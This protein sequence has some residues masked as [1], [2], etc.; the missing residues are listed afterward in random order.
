MAKGWIKIDRGIMEN[1]IYPKKRAFT[2]YEAWLH[3]LL[4]ANYS[5]SKILDNGQLIEVKR[6]QVLTSQL[7]LSTEFGWSRN[8]VRR[9][10]EMLEND[11]MLV[12]KTTRKYTILTICNYE[13][14]QGSGTTDDTTD[15]TTEGQLTEHIKECKESKEE[16]E[17]REYPHLDK[18]FPLEHCD[19]VAKKDE[20][21]VINSGYRDKWPTMFQKYLKGIGETE[22]HIGDYKKHFFN[23]KRKH[24]D[25]KPSPTLA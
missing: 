13:S 10:S 17:Q 18:K 25:Y 9:F 4:L 8:K 12:Q 7:Q 22:K 15:G 1:W 20:R 23:W 5:D 14:Y 6:G 21:W 3:L 2:E 16:K 11:G 19:E 24:P